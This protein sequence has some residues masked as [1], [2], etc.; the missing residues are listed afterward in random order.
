M[1]SFKA[2]ID[3]LN[4][5]E[6]RF[7]RAVEC[8]LSALNGIQENA[9]EIDPELTAAHQRIVGTLHGDL[10]NGP[11]LDSL[12]RSRPALLHA[13][14]DYR[15]KSAACQSQKE[16][17]LRAMLR[18]LGDA[19]ETLSRHNVNHSERLKEFTQQLQTVA[20]GTDLGQMRRDLN[21]QVVQLK[22]AGESMRQDN[23]GSVAQMQLKL[24]EFQQRLELAEQRASTDALTGLLNR[25]DGELRL[26]NH[27]E[28][29]GAISVILIDLNGFK[30]IN[31]RWGHTCGD[32]ILKSFSHTLASAVRPSDTACR[33][34]GDEFL[35]ILEGEQTVAQ[36]R[37]IQMQ[38][39]LRGRSK[40]AAIGKIFDIEVSASMGTAQARIGE[41]AEDLVSRA[42]SDMYRH[43]ET[44]RGP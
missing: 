10:S 25:G 18:T 33:W 36:Q 29:G 31:D 30:Q 14:Q 13:L 6:E 3:K 16:E 23:H 40:V 1:L 24:V 38:E 41:T 17:D 12:E 43:K 4:R 39:R 2:S 37:A 22:S 34:G 7:Q 28:Q 42:D 35:V 20:R 32:Q 11:D 8:Y 5:D 21:R 9:V 44:R 15:M 26:R 19:A 27:L